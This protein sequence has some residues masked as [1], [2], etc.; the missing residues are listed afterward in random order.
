LCVHQFRRDRQ[1]RLWEH[2]ANKTDVQQVVATPEVLP[3]LTNELSLW[4]AYDDAHMRESFDPSPDQQ[5]V[6]LKAAAPERAQRMIVVKETSGG[7]ADDL[8]RMSLGIEWG[9]FALFSGALLGFIYL[10]LSPTFRTR[11]TYFE[12][13]I[14]WFGYF[15]TVGL[16]V[17][18]VIQVVRRIKARGI[19]RRSGILAR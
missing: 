6:I 18:N 8:S 13:T 7:I 1:Y 17:L 19:K 12:T 16:T 11:P 2:P 14:V 15:S 10:S 5:K 3:R 9:R 4:L